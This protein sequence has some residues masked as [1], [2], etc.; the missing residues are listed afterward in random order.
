MSNCLKMMTVEE[1]PITT[2][3]Q[4]TVTTLSCSATSF[5]F[6]KTIFVVNED[7][8]KKYVYKITNNNEF[9]DSG[10]M[11]KIFEH[12]EVN[13]TYYAISNFNELKDRHIYYK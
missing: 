13:D 9:R 8:T 12:L 11:W 4:S 3:A 10:L 6:Y 2:T 5:V 1:P 7:F